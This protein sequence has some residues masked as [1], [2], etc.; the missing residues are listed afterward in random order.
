MRFGD[1]SY[2]TIGASVR[3]TEGL[4]LA[5]FRNGGWAG[6][7]ETNAD[8]TAVEQ[9]RATYMNA[10]RINIKLWYANGAYKIY[11]NN[12]LY[13]TYTAEQLGVN[14]LGNPVNVGYGCHLDDSLPKTVTF[15][16]ISA[17][18]E[19]SDR[20]AAYVASFTA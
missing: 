15:G 19:S 1:N 12:V 3:G 2:L 7:L 16:P 14:G 17:A 8:A 20:Y 11:L 5:F 4:K 9:L 18:P 6:Q 10:D 13:G